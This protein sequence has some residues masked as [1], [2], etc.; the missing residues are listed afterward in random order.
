[1]GGLVAGEC[2]SCGGPG[3]GDPAAARH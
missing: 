2:S 3:I 1:M